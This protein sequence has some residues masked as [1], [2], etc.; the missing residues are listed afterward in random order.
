MLFSVF[1]A[2]E[3]SADASVPMKMPMI[4]PSNILLFYKKQKTAIIFLQFKK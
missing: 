1:L 4:L 3:K 2:A